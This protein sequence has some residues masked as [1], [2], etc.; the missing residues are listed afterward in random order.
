MKENEF[1]DDTTLVTKRYKTLRECDHSKEVKNNKNE[2]LFANKFS[3]YNKLNYPYYEMN[4]MEL[5]SYCALSKEVELN[6][7]HDYYMHKHG[8]SKV[9]MG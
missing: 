2:I 4:N 9:D 6:G 1:F 5:R 8:S 3:T 7:I